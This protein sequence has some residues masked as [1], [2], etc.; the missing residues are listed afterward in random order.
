MTGSSTQQGAALVV[1]LVMLLVFTVLASSAFNLSSTN[2]KVVNN[3][4]VREEAIAAVNSAIEQVIVI[5]FMGSEIPDLTIDFDGM[6][7]GRAYR[8]IMHAPICLKAVPAQSVS[9]SSVNLTLPSTTWNTVWEIRGEVNDVA[10][11]AEA[12]VRVGVRVLLS[13]SKKI[14]YCSQ[15]NNGEVQNEA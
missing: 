1:G 4:Q 9:P 6:E 8:V 11:G 10:T 13:E 12:V 5:D 3:L 15:G 2:L 14:I 7:S